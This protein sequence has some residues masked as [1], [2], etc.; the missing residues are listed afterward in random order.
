MRTAGTV[1]LWDVMDQRFK[2]YAGIIGQE[3]ILLNEQIIG[4]KNATQN[5]TVSKQTMATLKQHGESLLDSATELD[6]GM[7]KSKA[8]IL[9]HY[10][11]NNANALEIRVRARD[12]LETMKHELFSIQFLPVPA[13]RKQYTQVD[14]FGPRVAEKF[15]SARYDISESG[16]CYACGRWTATVMHCMRVLEFG[17]DALRAALKVPSRNRGWR[18][19]LENLA[20]E[21]E[22]IVNSQTKAMPPLRW[23]RQFFPKL[24]AEIGHFEFAWRN[25]AMHAQAQYGEIE[26]GRVFEHVRSFMDLMSERL[27]EPRKK[28]RR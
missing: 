23:R 11:M 7:S 12:L 15:K 26:A 14:P 8:A 10:V 4:L 20:K 19:D 16:V 22:Q 9:L 2:E 18:I 21:W 24:F 5:D 1:S 28:R 27:R 3:F 6:L 25:H 17:L 13:N